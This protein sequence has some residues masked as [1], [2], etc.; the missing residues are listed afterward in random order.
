MPRLDKNNDKL[1]VYWNIK[2][3]IIDVNCT[4]KYSV[5]LRKCSFSSGANALLVDMQKSYVIF[6][7][8]WSPALRIRYAIVADVSRPTSFVVRPVNISRKLSKIGTS[9]HGTLL[10]SFHRR[11]C[12]RTLIR[13]E[14]YFW[15]QIKIT[16][17]NINVVSCSTWCQTTA[18]VNRSRPLLQRRCYQLLKTE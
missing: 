5:F 4:Q 15:F 16:R 13:P 2:F 18:V 7:F 6:H 9:Y 14:E 12:C 3:L 11:F 17:S 8:S 10:G 1:Y